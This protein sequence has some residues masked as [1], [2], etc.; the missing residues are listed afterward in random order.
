MT[1]LKSA[2]LAAFAFAGMACN[3]MDEVPTLPPR[4]LRITVPQGFLAEIYTSGFDLPT[5]IAFPPDGSDRLFVNELQSGTV[6]IVVDGARLAEPFVQVLT[7]TTGGFPVDGENG[8]L[9]IAFDPEYATNRYVYF[10]YA[11]RTDSGTFGSVARL[12]DVNNRGEDLTVLLEGIPSAPGHQIESLAFGPDDKLY[13]STGDAFMEDQVQDTDTF[14]GKIL[15]MNPDGSIPADNPF[16]NSYTY[17][18]GMRNGFDLV[19]DEAGNLYSTDN[20][21]DHSDEL[22]QIQEGGNYG[23]PMRLGYTSM[24][25]FVTPLHVWTQIV[26]PGG[27]IVYRG[28]QFPAAYRGKLLLV[29]FGFTFTQGPSDRAK[30][31]Q[32]VDLSSAPPVFQDFAVYDFAGFGNPLDIT[33]GP[34]GSIYLSDIFQGRIYRIRYT[35]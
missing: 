28:T 22:N 17:A 3:G 9:G 13:V 12:T 15:R 19:F 25:E 27:M 7:N 32:M 4:P 33:E 18:Y 29:L 2:F 16:A 34:D 23:W 1:Y 31:V 26:A 11:T 35:G 20:G 30:R 6:W 10:T 21:P 24:P 14:L 5:S 8:L